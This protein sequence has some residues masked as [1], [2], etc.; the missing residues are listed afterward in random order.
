MNRLLVASR[1][2]PDIDLPKYLG[3]SQ[4]SVV[5]FSL[6]TPLSLYY[7]ID[8]AANATELRDFQATKENQSIEEFSSN[9]RE[10][11]VIDGRL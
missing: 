10:V 4:F 11:V 1:T 7:L 8:K 9:A 2:R 5:P 3:I 6:L